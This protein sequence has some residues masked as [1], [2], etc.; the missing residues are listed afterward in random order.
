[1]KVTEKQYVSM[2]ILIGKKTV[3]ERKI[4]ADQL[5]LF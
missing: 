5:S 3:R 4:N 2:E 1:M